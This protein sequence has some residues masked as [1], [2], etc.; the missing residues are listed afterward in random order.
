MVYSTEPRTGLCTDGYRYVLKGHEALDVVRAEAVGYLLAADAHIP[1]PAWSFVRSRASEHLLFGSRMV[2]GFRDVEP[3]LR[4][5]AVRNRSDLC[6]LAALDVWICNPDRNIG[7]LIGSGAANGNTHDIIVLA[8]DFEKAV[9]LR[10]QSPGLDTAA[11]RPGTL[12][13]RGILHDLLRVGGKPD[14][15]CMAEVTA[16]WSASARASVE[17]VQ[18]SMG[19][20]AEW[21]ETT[22]TVLE[23]RLDRLSDL[24][25]EAW[26]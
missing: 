20:A 7:N 14:S 11:I 6:K 23:Q 24:V 22:V 26:I 13:P 2:D 4:R 1:T 19:L 9:T 5:G 8:I 16:A 21:A 3:F 12:V 15:A 18:R 10:G 25:E 17:C